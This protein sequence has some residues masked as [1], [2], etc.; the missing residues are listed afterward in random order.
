MEILLTSLDTLV[1]F[2]IDDPFDKEYLPI[3]R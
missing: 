1:E 3:A 2:L